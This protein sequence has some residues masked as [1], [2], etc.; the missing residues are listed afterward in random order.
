M[1][2]PLEVPVGMIRSNPRQPRRKFSEAALGELT[3]SI[4]KTGILQPLV[5][6]KTAGGYELIAGERRLRAA[7]NAGLERVPVVVRSSTD[8]NQLELAL[9]EN[10]Q[11][12]DLSPIEE[13][14]GYDRLMREFALTQEDVAAKVGKE[15][16][17][18]SNLLRLLKLPMSVQ[19]MIN[20]GTV[21]MGHA[22]A[23][24][25]L[26]DVRRQESLA[27]KIEKEGLSVRNVEELV[28]KMLSRPTP[29]ARRA[30]DQA[31]IDPNVRHLSEELQRALGTRV[32]VLPRGAGG[33]IRVQYYTAEDLR[34][35]TERFLRG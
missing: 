33:E 7:R 23:L 14:L 2:V 17:T 20:S 15:R 31:K 18:V 22:R 27:Q 5:V 25:P 29:S 6:R 16:S 9:I 8:E 30:N 13:A 34:R 4:K 24:L 28:R 26:E 3:E 35:L 19:E 11:R 1:G 12:E 32:E 10:L 21:S